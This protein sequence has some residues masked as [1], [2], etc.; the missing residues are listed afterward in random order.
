[1][2]SAAAVRTLTWNVMRHPGAPDHDDRAKSI[3]AVVKQL[4]LDVVM[5]QEAWDGLVGELVEHAG[6]LPAAQSRYGQQ[7]SVCAVLVGP[8]AQQV[9]Q[10]AELS[11]PGSES[12]WGYT[13]AFATAVISGRTWGLASAHLP[14]GGRSEAAR[15]AAVVALDRWIEKSLPYASAPVVLGADMNAQPHSLSWRTLTGLEPAGDAGPGPYWVDTW[16][17]TSPSEGR[18]AGCTVGPAVAPLAAETAAMFGSV[19]PDREPSR[20]ID[21]VFSR[22]WCYGRP[23]GPVSSLV[24]TGDMVR[25][26]SDHLP[27]LTVLAP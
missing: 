24:V 23:G 13:A 20:R 7:E 8:E 22:G 18:A 1:V 3:V 25:L 11:L 2:Q 5:L 12:G 17:A 10:G 26:C 15:V 19:R 9:G 27:V 6:L 4:N 14:W 21:G 16:A